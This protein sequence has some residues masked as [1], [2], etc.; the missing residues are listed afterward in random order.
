MDPFIL[1][2]EPL[3]RSGKDRY[4]RRPAEQR[5]DESRREVYEM[6]AIVEH[7]EN[8]T[9]LDRDGNLIDWILLQT[10]IEAESGSCRC[11]HLCLILDRS[12]VHKGNRVEGRA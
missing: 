9:T 6:L 2:A 3:A 12:Q 7:D 10:E 1:G 11:Q 8:A 5:F 4:A